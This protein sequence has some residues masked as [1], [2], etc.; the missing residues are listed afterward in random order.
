MLLE[1]MQNIIDEYHLIGW[2]IGLLVTAAILIFFLKES[3]T[4]LN[5]YIFDLLLIQC[6]SLCRRG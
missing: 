5:Q 1:D 4:D 2:G 3:A 6:L